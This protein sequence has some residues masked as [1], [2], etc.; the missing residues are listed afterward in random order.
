MES[1]PLVSILLPIRNAQAFLPD[2][3]DSICQQQLTRWELLAVDDHSTDDSAAIVQAYAQRDARIRLLHNEGRGIIPALRLAYQHSQAPYLTRMDADDRMSI[4]KL[5]HMYAQLQ[6]AGRGHLATGLV[7]YFSAS[8]LGEGY[9]K[10]QDWL[11]ELTRAGR[12]FSDIYRECVIPSP[13]WML[14]RQDLDRSGAFDREVYPEDYDLC[15]RFYQQNLKVLPSDRVLH[16]WR[17]SPGRSSRTDPNYADNRFLDIKLAYFLRLDRQQER[18]L[19]LWG[20]G[21]KGKALARKLREQKVAFH[22]L[23]NNPA[24][25]GRDIYG[26][27]LMGEDQLADFSQPQVLIAVAGDAQQAQIK[28]QLSQQYIPESAV[29]FFC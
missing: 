24:K 6:G 12:N 14:H 29:F 5:S 28:A 9:R 23:C 10:Y 18:P 11:N 7:R 4:D 15:F 27:R 26:Q 20:A 1:E 13:C 8:P 2:C 22:W 25:I 16:H 17:D 3:L 19:V 21:K